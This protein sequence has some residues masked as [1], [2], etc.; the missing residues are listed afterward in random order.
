ME[1]TAAAGNARAKTGTMSNVSAL[2]GFVDTQDGETLTFAILAN[3]HQS[4]AS[5]IARIIDKAV[6]ALASFAR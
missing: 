2:S 1:G 4:G 6:G 5:E 3:N